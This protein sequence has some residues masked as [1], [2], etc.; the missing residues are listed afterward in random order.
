MQIYVELKITKIILKFFKFDC[1][2]FYQYVSC[3]GLFRYQY[4]LVN[5]LASTRSAESSN[6][7]QMT[8]LK[9]TLQGKEYKC[10]VKRFDTFVIIV[11]WQTY[12][13]VADCNVMGTCAKRKIRTLSYPTVP[14]WP[15][16]RSTWKIHTI[17]VLRFPDNKTANR[18]FLPLSLF[19]FID[20]FVTHPS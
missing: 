17:L 7:R 6:Q 19:W 14:N 10:K 18:R 5:I 9:H 2:G 20:I 1:L 16:S 13:L 3:T 11:D 8:A 12:F 4:F 15:Y